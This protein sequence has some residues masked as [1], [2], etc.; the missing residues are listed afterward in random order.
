MKDAYDTV[1]TEKKTLA[2]FFD[3]A[4]QR[5]AEYYDTECDSVLERA[6][7]LTKAQLFDWAIDTVMSIPPA[8]SACYTRAQK[9]AVEIFEAQQ[10]QN[11]EVLMQA[12]RAALANDNT[13][14]ALKL[15]GNIN[16]TSTCHAASVRLMQG[17]S[18]KL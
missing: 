16:P 15:L 6:R 7:T 17:F 14:K 4:R 10:T 1:I 5:I 11:C 8:A 3:T 2:Q 12:A 18:G 9:A 13:E